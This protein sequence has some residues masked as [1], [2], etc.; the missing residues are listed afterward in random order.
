MEGDYVLRRGRSAV[1]VYAGWVNRHMPTLNPQ[2]M[3]EMSQF[4]RNRTLRHNRKY[5]VT[6]VPRK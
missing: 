1:V 6:I 2:R 4:I 3:G 5:L